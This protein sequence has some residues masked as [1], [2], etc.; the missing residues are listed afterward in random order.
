[1]PKDLYGSFEELRAREVYGEDYSISISERLSELL[2]L[3]PHGGYIEP[4]T[5]A[6][7]RAV[8]ADDLS[9]YLFEGLREDRRH[10]ELHITSRN[11]DEPGAVALAAKAH[12][13]VSIHGRRNRNDPDAVWLG[14]LDMDARHAICLH[15]DQAGFPARNPGDELFALDPMNIC[16]RGRSGKG[17]QLELPRGLRDSLVGDEGRMGDFAGAIRAAIL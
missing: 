5:S 4:S 12:R 2:I 17:V 15:L 13:V 7:A 10:H 3:A 8:A 9:F 11:F 1:M 14:G 6:V 16:N